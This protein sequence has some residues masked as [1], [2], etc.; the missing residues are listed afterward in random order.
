VSLRDSHPMLRSYRI[1]DGQI[2]EEP[3]VLGDD[4]R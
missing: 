1:V 2:D 3:V 4:R